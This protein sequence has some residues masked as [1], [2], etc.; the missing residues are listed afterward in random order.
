M[1]IDD[2]INDHKTSFTNKLAKLVSFADFSESGQQIPETADY[3]V[4]LLKRLLNANV[5]VE[6]TAGSP[7]IVATINPGQKHTYLFYGHYDVQTPGN[8]DDWASDPFALTSK[9]GR[10]YGRGVGD[11]KGQLMAQI[12]GF[13]VFEQLFGKLP[14]TAKLFIEGEEE[15]G[16][17]H[18][19]PTDKKLKKSALSDVEAA[20]VVDGSM[21]QSGKHVLRL[22]NRG[23]L[24]FRITTHTAKTAL[25]SGNFGNVS[26]DAITE[27][28]AVLNKLLDFSTYEPK[29]PALKQN[30]QPPTPQENKWLTE[31]PAPGETPSPLFHG[32]TDYYRRLMFKPTFTINGITGGYEGPKAKTIIP[33]E[34]TAVL[35]SRLVANQ[36]CDQ[37][38]AGIEKLLQPEIQEGLVTIKWLVTLNPTKTCSDHPLIPFIKEAI[39][40]ATGDCLIEPTMPGSV[41][42]DVW[43]ETLG[44]PVFTI[45]YANYDQHNHAANENL[46]QSAYW[47]GIKITTELC[48]QLG[49]YSA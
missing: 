14:F 37:V 30:I 45:P 41:P 10:F 29:V 42:N 46:L 34:A 11:N 49:N 18:L 19:Q 22:G 40:Q 26:R 23:D 8:L 28:M 25:H 1:Q 13:S 33:G 6:Q 44:V 15:S 38:Q 9:D 43:T 35:D 3:L 4:N 5:E 31:L 12:C 24:A 39:T 7:V 36:R 20:F 16:S 27:L 32:Q 2:F 48:Q 47:D 17:P 21:S